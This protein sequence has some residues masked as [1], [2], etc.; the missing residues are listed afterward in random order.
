MHEKVGVPI[1]VVPTYV[2]PFHLVGLG[3]LWLVVG[4]LGWLA[5]SHH[6]TYDVDCVCMQS[7]TFSYIF[8]PLIIYLWCDV[9]M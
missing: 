2:S 1:V 7:C 3:W 6:N 4:L 8:L 9:H 5:G